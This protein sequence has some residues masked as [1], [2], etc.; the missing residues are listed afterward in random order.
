MDEE[1][2]TRLD[3]LETAVG[4]MTDQDMAN[5]WDILGKHGELLSKQVAAQMDLAEVVLGL[6]TELDELKR[7]LGQAN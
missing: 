4:R 3:R 2:K 1:I 7:R 5:A 6:R